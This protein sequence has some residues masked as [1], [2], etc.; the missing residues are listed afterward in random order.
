MRR[1]VIVAA[2]LGVGAVVALVVGWLVIGR[3]SVRAESTVMPGVAIECAGPTGVSAAT[4]AAWGDDILRRGP[5]SA[6]FGMEDLA[7]LE[8][9]REAWGFAGDCEAAFFIGRY[10]DDPVWTEDVPCLDEE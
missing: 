3:P 1:R 2:A 10:P 8:V 6:T 5:P 7:R 9:R 4:C